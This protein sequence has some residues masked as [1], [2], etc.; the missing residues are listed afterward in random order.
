MPDPHQAPVV[1]IT[2]A[3]R[4][5]GLATSRRFREAGWYV[6]A[7]DRDPPPEAAADRYVPTDL[8]DPDAISALFE[9][10][11]RIECRCICL[12]NNAAVQHCGPVGDVALRDFDEVMNVNVRAAFWCVR[13]ALPLLRAQPGDASVVNVASVHAV[14]T[15]TQIV[16][17]ATSKGALCAMTR[18]LALDLAPEG[19]RVN[20]VL[21][22]AVD[23]PMLRDGLARGLVAGASEDAVFSAF[24]RRHVMGRVGRPEEIAEAILFLAS[25]DRASYITGASLTVDGGVTVALSTEVRGG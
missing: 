12:V 9:S 24:S 22:G 16:A 25:S 17:Y 15:S 19:I 7:A 11:T 20:A 21:P 3:T 4:G 18:A 23:T 13:Q 5:I 8:T 2:G 1:V 6:V 10:I 14:A